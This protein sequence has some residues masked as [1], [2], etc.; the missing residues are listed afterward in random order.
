[1]C[2]LS[3]AWKGVTRP[4]RL[5]NP[6]MQTGGGL[7]PSASDGLPQWKAPPIEVSPRCIIPLSRHL[8]AYSRRGWPGRWA[9]PRASIER[10]VFN[11][12]RIDLLTCRV[13]TAVRRFA[14]SG[15][16]VGPPV[17]TAIHFGGSAGPY[18]LAMPLSLP[19]G[20]AGYSHRRWSTQPLTTDCYRSLPRQCWQSADCDLVA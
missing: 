18:A 14:A 10:D 19:A 7:H 16:S 6:A 4:S 1:M 12:K 9:L 5:S 17:C 13:L 20:R 8:P 15:K 3:S 11:D 2:S